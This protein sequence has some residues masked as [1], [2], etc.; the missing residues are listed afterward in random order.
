MDNIIYC[1]IEALK[2]SVPIKFNS[3]NAQDTIIQKVSERISVIRLPIYEWGSSPLFSCTETVEIDA[4]I[5][6]NDITVKFNCQSFGNAYSVDIGGFH[7]DFWKAVI[8]TFT[9]ALLSKDVIVSHAACIEINGKY[10]LL[11][12]ISGGG[13]SSISFECMRRGFPVYASELCYLERGHIIAGNLSASID[14]DALKYFGMPMPTISEYKENRV[15]VDTNPLIEKKK[16]EQVLFPKVTSSGLH[17]R[18]ITIRRGRMLLYENIF[19]QLPS[20]QLLCHNSIPI[21][22]APTSQQLEIIAKQVDILLDTP[23]FIVE[24]TPR[25]IVDWLQGSNNK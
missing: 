5:F 7:W 14:S 1:N 18:P 8:A 23:P 12:G 4:D 3:K 17:V 15:L 9:G 13:K 22:P 11:P 20:G 24:G 21:L 25:E 6:E 19:G 16:I 10:I 2:T